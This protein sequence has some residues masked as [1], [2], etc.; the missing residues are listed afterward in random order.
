VFTTEVIM[1]R[2]KMRCVEIAKRSYHVGHEQETVKLQPVY[3]P[4]NETWSAATPSGSVE[5][6]ITNPAALAQFEVGGEY[7]VDFARIPAG[8]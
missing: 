4:G 6:A 1:V 7:M 5:L 8:E 2:C 3:G